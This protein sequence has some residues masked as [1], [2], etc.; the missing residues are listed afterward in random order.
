M[1]KVIFDVDGVLL[2]E[3]RYF[4]VS[5]LTVW[6]WFYSHAYMRLG[7]EDVKNELTDDEIDS[8][9]SRI[10]D[11]DKI[12]TWL[13]KHGVNNNW[14]MVHARIVV[15][16]WLMMEAYINDHGKANTQIHTIDD[17]QYLGSLLQG[18]GIPRADAVLERLES[19]VPERAGKDDVF[20]YLTKA[21]ESSLGRA[22]LQ[23]TPL[24]SPLWQLHFEAFQ[25]WYFGDELYEQTYHKKPAAPGKTGFLRRE[26]P[27]GTP[28]SI[29]AMFQTLKKRGYQIAIATGRSKPEVDVPFT[30]YHWLEEF[31]PLYVATYTDVLAA[32]KQLHQ[33][34]DKPN[35][36][37]YY[38]GAFGKRPDLYADYI[39]RP[40]KYKKGTYYIVGDSV[41]D[42]WCA[43]AMGAIMIGT[44][45]GL[46]GDM[47]RPMFAKEHVPYVVKT[48]EDILDILK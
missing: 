3:K 1:K 11:D 41:A 34:L 36:F 25:E 35:P 32:E 40:E 14:D 39:E 44:L 45:T 48:V 9:R 10:W 31:D 27:F 20:Q 12:L 4:D 19:V 33:S 47:A 16:L 8:I 38:L 15:T 17:V 21:V 37:A 22:S 6:E 13:K 18:Y 24:Q 43:K 29:K 2:S 28:E 26:E 46:D 23:W 30:T 42:V 5:A 7:H